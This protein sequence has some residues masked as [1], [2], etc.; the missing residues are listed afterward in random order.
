MP[1]G[2]CGVL[3]RDRPPFEAGRAG[4]PISKKT[5]P[6]RL[7]NCR[8]SCYCMAPPLHKNSRSPARRAGVAG[9]VD[10][11]PVPRTNHPT[12]RSRPLRPSYNAHGKG[13]SAGQTMRAVTPAV[14]RSLRH[15]SLADG[16]AEMPDGERPATSR[17]RCVM[18]GVCSWY[19]HHEGLWWL[20]LLSVASLLM[21]VFARSARLGTGIERFAGGRRGRDRR[22]PTARS[23]ERRRARCLVNADRTR[24]S[25]ALPLEK[26]RKKR[27]RRWCESPRHEGNR[28]AGRSRAPG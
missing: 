1:H 14:A 5:G 19:A 10:G 26:A 9:Q 22:R 7:V 23:P 27:P 4:L 24:A 18:W 25:Q 16:V 15:S 12:E 2:G 20:V 13:E 28:F 6:C 21:G 8:L 11:A 3:P 17:G